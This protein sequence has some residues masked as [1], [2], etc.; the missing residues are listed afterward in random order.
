ML[1]S[2]TKDLIARIWYYGGTEQERNN[3]IT[4]I[5]STHQGHLVD[6]AYSGNAFEMVKTFKEHDGP[7]KL[8]IFDTSNAHGTTEEIVAT[9][10]TLFKGRLYIPGH[11]MKPFTPPSM[12][13]AF[14]DLPPAMDIQVSGQ[15][16]VVDMLNG[17]VMKYPVPALEVPETNS[18]SN[19]K[20]ANAMRGGNLDPTLTSL[21]SAVDASSPTDSDPAAVSV[22]V[23]TAG[24]VGAEGNCVRWGT[25]GD[26]EYRGDIPPIEKITKKQKVTS[27][28]SKSSTKK[29]AYKQKVTARRSKR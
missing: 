27:K 12:V 7:K 29:I 1:Q 21:P 8:V 24:P 10:Q 19:P 5:Q 6:T 17:E 14:S 2:F 4:T 15:W 22:E 11:G 9:T 25:N 13:L 23:H 16:R 20:D 3:V 18:T 26:G 28:K